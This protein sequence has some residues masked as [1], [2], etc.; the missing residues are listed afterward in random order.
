VLIS[1]FKVGVPVAS[2]ICA[3]AFPGLLNPLISAAAAFN[4]V[5]SDT[6]PVTIRS[7]AITPAAGPITP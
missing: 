7:R 5:W 1:E 4:S 3:D 6:P 2:T